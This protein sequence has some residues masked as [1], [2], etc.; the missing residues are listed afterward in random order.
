MN[1]KAMIYKFEGLLYNGIRMDENMISIEENLPII[2]TIIKE[3]YVKNAKG[4]L[5]L[6]DATKRLEKVTF[7]PYERTNE[8]PYGYVEEDKNIIWYAKEANPVMILQILTHEIGHFIFDR[9]PLIENGK[10]IYQK[11]GLYE[12][13]HLYTDKEYSRGYYLAE[14]L[15]ESFCTTIWQDP[16]FR[17]RIV[18]L[19]YSIKNYTYKDKELFHEYYF[20]TE[21]KVLYELCNLLL[22]N[23]LWEANFA[24]DTKSI[25]DKFDSV[26]SYDF[27]FLH[28][29]KA[30][31]SLE[32]LQREET[33]KSHLLFDTH[34]EVYLYSKKKLL[35]YLKKILKKNEKQY[36]SKE[37]KE[38]QKLWVFY[39]EESR[40]IEFFPFSKKQIEMIDSLKE[41]KEVV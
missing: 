36:S 40:I 18:E 30:C 8:E 9:E 17:N 4:L 13:F 19:G 2:C 23:A 41:R 21:Y 3:A 1:F 28:Y 26:Y 34:L 33:K 35:G 6:T 20:Y 14:G 5:P 15:I 7:K 37:K 29:K 39:F 12:R 24:L 31:L 25:K 22:K 11:R 27:F 10:I 16:I 32:E 38:I